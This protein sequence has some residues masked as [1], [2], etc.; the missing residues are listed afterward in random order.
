MGNLHG[1]DEAMLYFMTDEF[2]HRD[3]GLPREASVYVGF[4]RGG[5]GESNYL[6]S[7]SHLFNIVSTVLAFSISF[8]CASLY[9]T[10]TMK[11]FLT[12]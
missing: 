2:F 1:E 11:G 12:N 5:G 9:L 10:G 7:P 6:L 4:Q 3:N 8:S